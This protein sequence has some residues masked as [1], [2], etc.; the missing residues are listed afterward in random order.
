MIHATAII[1]PSAVIGK[2]VEIGPYSIIGKNV[3]VGD[4]CKIGPHVV[5]QGPTT[6]GRETQIF[7]FSSIGEVP[8]DKKYAGEETRLEIGE[9]NV[10]R[11]GCT[12]N[13]GTSQDKTVTRIGND[14]WIMAYVHIAHDCEVGNNTILANNVALAG[15]VSVGDY[16]ILGGFTLVHQFCQIGAHCFTAMGSA[17]AKDIPPFVMA[18]G[19]PAKP[20]GLNTEGLKRRGYSAD[21]IKAIKQAY[22]IIYRSG[23]TLDEARTDL[24]EIAKES[25]HVSSMLQFLQSVTR[26]IIR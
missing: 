15:H 2:N 26:G 3:V 1:D 18:S 19:N 7:Q 14:N 17:V 6:I 24:S 11:E 16:A 13:R 9:R 22:K 10:I 20:Y 21:D 25:S 5:I 23:K 8:Q 12:F 4:E